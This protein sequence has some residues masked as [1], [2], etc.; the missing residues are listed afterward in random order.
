[1]TGAGRRGWGQGGTR[2]GAP[3]GVSLLLHACAGILLVFARPSAPAARPPMY[4][5]NIVAAPPGPR[6]VG[7]VTPAPA[8]PPDEA[9][10]PPKR[11]ESI[12]KAM[13]LPDKVPPRRKQTSQATPTPV[14]P[15]AKPRETEAPAKAGGGPTGG[16]GTDV[17]TVRTE[18]VDFPF[19]G[20]LENIVRQ[21]ALRF[22]AP[23]NTAASAEVMFL[24]HRDGSISNFR[25][26][27]RS[28]NFAFDLEAQGAVDQAGQVKSFGPLPAG[29][30]DDVLPVIFSF[31]PRVLR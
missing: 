17:A 10:P 30:S 14:P 13:P 3:L 23:G 22:N 1:M 20:Y 5:V 7:V 26:L 2:L 31:D 24:V 11:A 12:P 19:P 25:F 6:A 8:P 4:R 15:A 29:F 16:R 21:I 9:A 27:T 18:G 28:G